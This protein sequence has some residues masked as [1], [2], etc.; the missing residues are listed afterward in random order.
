MGGID[1]IDV[2]GDPRVKKLSA[3]VRGVNYGK[4][5]TR[6]SSSP[7][8]CR[9]YCKH[10]ADTHSSGY[11]LAE[12][13]SA[14]ARASIFLVRVDSVPRNGL[15]QLKADAYHR[16]TVIQIYQPR[17]ECRFLCSWI[18]VFESSP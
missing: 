15:L 12:P 5:K 8:Y 2:W 11:W 6:I 9:V 18:L 10:G 3:N 14:P 13:E 4:R 17:G 16:F 1:T 7:E